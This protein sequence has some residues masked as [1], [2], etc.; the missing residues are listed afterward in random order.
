MTSHNLIVRVDFYP[1]GE[2]I[3]LGFT[4][5]N[6]ESHYVEKIVKISYYVNKT[7]FT[8]IFSGMNI[9]LVCRDGV[10]TLENNS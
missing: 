2:M 9:L 7:V 6:G 8:C 4:D 5:K 1:N 3:P 10:W